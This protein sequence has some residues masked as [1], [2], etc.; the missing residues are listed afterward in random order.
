MGVP[1]RDLVEVKISCRETNIR[2]CI[3]PNR[4][5]VPVGDEDPLADI[6]LAALHNQRILDVLLADVQLPILLV[7]DKL[8]AILELDQ[9]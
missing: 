5:W 3:D 2:L 1:I 9:V 7:T 6:K 8:I 4:Q